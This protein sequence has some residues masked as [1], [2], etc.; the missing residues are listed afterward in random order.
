MSFDW[1]LERRRE[2]I[3]YILVDEIRKFGF[4]ANILFTALLNLTQA[5]GINYWT[6]ILFCHVGLLS[7]DPY[8][9]LF[10]ESASRVAHFSGN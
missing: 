3:P 6:D 8:F 9:I 1:E 2:F 4:Q 5:R 7:D 10:C